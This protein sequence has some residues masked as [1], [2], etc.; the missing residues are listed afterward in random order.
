MNGHA[1]SC[2]RCILPATYPGITFNDEGIC[3]YCLGYRPFHQYLGNTKLLEV[4][5]SQPTTGTFDCVV[6]ISGGKDS[7]YILYYTVKILGLRPIA[8]MH[9]SGFQHPLAV[10]NARTACRILHVPLQEIDSSGPLRRSMLKE[11]LRASET[12]G[13]I[14]HACGNCEA[15][16]RTAAVKTAREAGTP[17]I[18][19]GSSALESGD[20]TIYLQ[21]KNLGADGGPM[22]VRLW[23][24]VRGKARRLMHDPRFASSIM[25]TLR[26]YVGWHALRYS[27]LSIVQRVK[28]GFP[29]GYALRPHAV[30]PFENQAAVFVHFFDYIQ[31]DSISNIR[32][33]QKE[34]GWRHP[35]GKESRWDCAIHCLGNYESLQT[36]GMSIEGINSCNFI[37]EEKMT[38]A[39]ALEK[40]RGIT[41]SVEQE[42][43]ALIDELGI[44]GCR[45]PGQ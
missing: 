11:S 25:H 1:Q 30:P 31:W 35:E 40:E 2:S 28:L 4:L 44:G 41:E 16:L 12:L 27:F 24:R 18:M 8:V 33:L 22:L 26:W 45:L 32:I 43:S 6:P 20:A 10:E 19:W 39:D 29:L 5:R 21:Y 13:E 38:R 42:C 34:V 3:N 9:N 17:F 36:T 14:W 15:I 7:T 23:K 37:R